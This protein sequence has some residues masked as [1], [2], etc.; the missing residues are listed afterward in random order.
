MRF[1]GIGDTCD[2]G[3][4]YIRLAAEGHEVRVAISEPLCHGTLAGMIPRTE[5]WRDD[6]GWIR[7]AGEDGIILFEGVTDGAGA[8]QD[9]LR[10]EGYHVIGGCAFGDRLENDRAYALGILRELGLSIAATTEFD[11]PE[12]SAAHIAAHPGRYVLKFNRTDFGAADNYVGQLSDGR[13]VQAMVE[14]KFRQIGEE[15]ITF[16]LMKHVSGIEMGVGAFFNG[17]DFITPACLDWEHKK[18]F[19]GDLGELT[20]EMGTVATYERTATF[21]AKTL[22][23]MAPLLRAH[24]YCGYINLNTIVNADGIWPLEFTCRFGYPGFAVLEPLQATPW[25]VLLKSMTQ[26]SGSPLE[27]RAG[28]SIGVLMTTRPFPYVSSYIPEP[29]GLP[30]MFEGA[31]SEGD[32]R[33]IHYGEMGLAGEQLVTAGYHG[34]TMVVTGTGL[35]IAEAQDKAYALA[36]RVVVPNLRYR[37]DIGTKL[38]NA[39]FAALERLGMF[40]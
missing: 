2:L 26:R 21:F 9:A 38:M 40:G 12:Q 15:R 22:A 28:F 20:G 19:P 36:R 13:D 27:T 1:L 25:S 17:E 32:R 37:N 4:L 3:S 8:H 39:D 7:A 16:V 34:W 29:T 31:L 35:T 24:H 14:A 23:P 30:I 10:A 5:N 18:F 33:N 6:L 11:R